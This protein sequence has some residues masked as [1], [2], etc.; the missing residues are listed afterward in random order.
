VEFYIDDGYRFSQAERDTIEAIAE[1]A[2]PEIRRFLP[3]LPH[4]LVLKVHS[5]KDVIPETG[6]TGSAAGRNPVVNWVVDPHRP[7][8]ASGIARRELRGTLFHE[9]HHLVR[10]QTL[11][12]ITLMDR[13]VGEGLATVFERDMAGMPA[14]W[15]NYPANVSD[16]VG[17]LMSLPSDI[18]SK[19]WMSRH[20]D[21][22]RWIG[23]KA[24][25]YLADR[26]ITAS[27]KSAA[28]LVLTPTED[29]LRMALPQ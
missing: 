26:A 4:D 23:Y 12:A 9:L 6:E 8:G 3:S 11:P 16:W 21:G 2:I 14:P 28:E 19:R 15:G 29:V 13:V 7:E 20:P 5:G 10:F 18:Q 24:G 25:T 1:A 27:R 17:E 22:R